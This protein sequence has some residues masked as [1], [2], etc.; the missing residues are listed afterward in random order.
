M[1]A[2]QVYALLGGLANLPADC[3]QKLGQDC[4][5]VKVKRLLFYLADGRDHAWLKR[6][7][8]ASMWVNANVC[9]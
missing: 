9:S 8:R 4:A 2:R 5:S 6:L 7:S 3:L 1:K